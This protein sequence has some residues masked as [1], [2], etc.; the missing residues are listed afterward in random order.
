MV[1][2][3]LVYMTNINSIQ[4]EC[5]EGRISSVEA[6]N[7]IDIAIGGI[8]RVEFHEGLKFKI[9]NHDRIISLTFRGKRRLME[10]IHGMAVLA[11]IKADK[12]GEVHISREASTKHHMN[13]IYEI[14]NRYQN[15]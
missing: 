8:T 10:R 14:L 6:I 4:R 12:T 3:F 9:Q 15:S 7:Q 2:S 5:L 11:Y 1:A 13:G